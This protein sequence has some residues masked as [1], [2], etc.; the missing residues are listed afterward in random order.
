VSGVDASY[1]FTT[2]GLH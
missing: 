1:Q 2:S